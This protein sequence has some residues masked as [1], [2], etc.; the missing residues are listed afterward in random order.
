VETTT[1]APGE[2]G[3]RLARN[4]GWNMAGQ[5]LP[6]VAAFAA[7]PVVVRELG[8]ERFGLL[9]LVWLVLGY[10]NLF[11]LGL[12]RATVKLVSEA[13]GRG[14]R[15]DA[16]SLARVSGYAH[17]GL[18]VVAALGLYLAVPWLVGAVF[19][20][21]PGMAV[22]TARV[23]RLLAFALPFV[24]VMHAH[25]SVLEGLQRFGVANALKVPFATAL[26]L[27][28]LLGV[29]LGWS[30]PGIVAAMVATRV[31]AA[32]AYAVAAARAFP[33]GGL[34][35]PFEPRLLRALLAF[36]GWIAV[37]NTVVPL[38]VYLDRL[39]ITALHSL[40]SL[41]YYVGAYEVAS[42][43]LLV[44]IAVSGAA[45]PLFSGLTA[46][47]SARLASRTADASRLVILLVTPV[48]VVLILCSE[49]LLSAYLGPDYA[50]AGTAVFV[51]LNVAVFLNALAFVFS[52]LVEGVGRPDVIAKYHLAELPV[53][54]A[55]LIALAGAYG[56]V[57][58]AAAWLLRMAWTV[59]VFVFI[60]ARVAGLRWSELRALGLPRDARD[61]ALAVGGACAIWYFARP[62]WLL[63]LSASGTVVASYAL[64]N[65]F[66][67]FHARE[68]AAIRALATFCRRPG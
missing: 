64:Y 58:A 42:K 14:R 52:A 59:P 30:M 47:A 27:A 54:L 20:V 41:A 10:F 67:R 51:L 62:G 48:S 39:T 53:Y 31:A 65:W 36:S 22:E 28:P 56:I 12:G 29:A 68:R 38:V 21:A 13:V 25:R 37:S 18:G 40:E 49:P 61:A 63:A 43:A 9:G 45:L 50:A 24:L 66:A 35:A 60:A 5:A 7:L 34:R 3:L 55:V 57:G 33:A 32:A 4:A 16:A 26:Y 6:L 11:D 8:P 15:R 23:L 44:P 19:D 1:P 46:A 2:S 17:A